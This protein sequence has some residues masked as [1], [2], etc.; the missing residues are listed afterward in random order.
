M[1]VDCSV[2][3]RRWRRASIDGAPH[4]HGFEMDAPMEF[5][6]SASLD[7]TG[8]HPTVVSGVRNYVVLKTT[9]SAFMKFYQGKYTTL[10]DAAERC[11]STS[12]TA[13]WQTATGDLPAHPTRTRDTVLKLLKASFFG[14]PRAGTFSPSVQD[15]LYKMGC[16]VLTGVPELDEICLDL[17]NI[18]FIPFPLDKY[19]EKVCRSSAL[20]SPCRTRTHKHTRVYCPRPMFVKCTYV[21]GPSAPPGPPP[22]SPCSPPFTSALFVCVRSRATPV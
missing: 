1:G 21:C 13:T 12:V 8:K 17:P 7:R 18:H 3:E 22:C 4:N 6:A 20:F 9:Q 10:P 16:A 11:L 15:A 5:T 14:P 2:V 19:G